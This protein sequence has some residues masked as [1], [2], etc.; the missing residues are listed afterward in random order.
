MSQRG[1]FNRNGLMA[2]GHQT[3]LNS[4]VPVSDY[5][6]VVYS[7][8]GAIDLFGVLSGMAAVCDTKSLWPSL[9]GQEMGHG[10]ELDHSRA[11]G[12]VPGW[13]DQP[14]VFDDGKLVVA[15]AGLKELMQGCSGAHNSRLLGTL[16]IVAPTWVRPKAF[17]PIQAPHAI[18]ENA[19]TLQ[20]N[21]L[22]GHENPW[23][24]CH[25]VEHVTVM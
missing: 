3:A 23:D 17:S 8:A 16:F 11:D 25:L 20:S 1:K 14:Y 7:F 18:C 10:Y 4:K 24:A 6:G 5:D 2:L 9:L 19:V 15:Y 13:T 22:V 12:E 21:A